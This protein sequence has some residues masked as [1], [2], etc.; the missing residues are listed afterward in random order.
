M[1]LQFKSVETPLNIVLNV[2]FSVLRLEVL[3]QYTWNRIQTGFLGSDCEQKPRTNANRIANKFKPT[4]DTPSSSVQAIAP[5][6]LR[7]AASYMPWPTD[8]VCPSVL[9][10]WLESRWGTRSWSWTNQRSSHR[11]KDR[12]SMTY[13]FR[14][15]YSTWRSAG[16]RSALCI[17]SCWESLYRCPQMNPLWSAMPPEAVALQFP[18]DCTPVPP[19]CT[20]NLACPASFM[21]QSHYHFPLFQ[22]KMHVVTHWNLRLVMSWQTPFYQKFGV[23]SLFF[24][25]CTWIVNSSVKML[26]F[27]AKKVGLY[28]CAERQMVDLR[29]L[30]AEISCKQITYLIVTNIR[31]KTTRILRLR[32][33]FD[34]N[35]QEIFLWLISLLRMATPFSM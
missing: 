21:V 1:K 10:Q 15:Q 32:G 18:W 20:C 24:N 34:T 2:S 12:W 9:I 33:L 16:S 14:S 30:K 17:R 22:C 28:T 31:Y 35:N 13:R 26:V 25:C 6:R 5:T 11:P 8:R 19:D 27:F 29:G 4:G 23:T 3:H 7:T